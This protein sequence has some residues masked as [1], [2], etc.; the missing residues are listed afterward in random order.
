MYTYLYLNI[1]TLLG[2]LALSFD[3]KV[4]FYKKW[5]YLFPAI[6]LNAVI[7]LVWDQFFTIWKIWW[8]NP[9]HLT[10]LY[11]FDLPIEEVMFFF[12]VPYACLFIYECLKAYFPNQHWQKQSNTI[13]SSILIINII[14]YLFYHERA[15]TAVTNLGLAFL[16]ILLF[17]IG[18]RQFVGRLFQA[19]LVSLIPFIIVNGC[20]TSLPV[21]LY[22]DKENM[23]I[24]LGSIPSDDLIYNLFMLLLTATFYEGFKRNKN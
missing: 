8:F 5:K 20:L 18:K 13:L 24:R 22:D 21:V 15:Y 11:L 19:Y 1:F 3:K 9:E 6:L 16:I 2:P 10:G 4:A 12:T 17:L 7:F 14:L 23:G